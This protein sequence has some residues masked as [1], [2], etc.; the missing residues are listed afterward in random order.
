MNAARKE[1]DK[2]TKGTHHVVHK[3]SGG[4]DVKKGGSSKAS[5]HYSTKKEAVDAARVISQ[6]Q[7]TELIIHGLNGRI[8]SCD[9]HGS[10]PCPPKD[11]K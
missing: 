7:H 6:N 4:W 5:G 3:P 2:M 11:K 9:S 8:Q 1:E 10:D